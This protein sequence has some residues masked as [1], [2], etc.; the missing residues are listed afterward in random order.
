V[1]VYV[2]LLSFVS[3]YVFFCLVR[4]RLYV[5]L[6]SFV[7][8]YVFLLS[9]VSVY[10]FLFVCVYM[11]VVLRLRVNVPIRLKHLYL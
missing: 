6:I 8:V 3:V 10:M 1:C 5:F 4:R 2:F 11:R 7:C 9:F